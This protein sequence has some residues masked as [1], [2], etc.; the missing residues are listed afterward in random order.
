MDL[1]MKGALVLL[2]ESIKA[3]QGAGETALRA[4]EPNAEVMIANRIA[5][6]GNDAHVTLIQPPAVKAMVE[7]IAA[8]DGCSKNAARTTLLAQAS[9]D[10]VPFVVNGVPIFEPSVLVPGNLSKV[11]KDGAVSY[12]VP[13][14]WARGQA[15]RKLMGLPPFGF[16]VTVGFNPKD[17]NDVA[18]M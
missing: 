14:E 7:A 18:K 4:I 1:A 16:H 13:V 5:R 12:Y 10:L 11:E 8:K 15:I 6:D 3:I 9:V 17:I 2:D